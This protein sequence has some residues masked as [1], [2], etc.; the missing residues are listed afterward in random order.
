MRRVWIN[1]SWNCIVEFY[2]A[3]HLLFNIKKKQTA[4]ET[5]LNTSNFQFWSKL[6]SC[7]GEKVVK[8]KLKYVPFLV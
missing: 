7:E 3:E 8:N 5:L 1:F 2:L 6:D 4:H